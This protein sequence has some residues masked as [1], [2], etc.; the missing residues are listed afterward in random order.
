MQF[1]LSLIDFSI[2]PCPLVLQTLGGS[3]GRLLSLALLLLHSLDRSA[4]G[5]NQRRL[6]RFWAPRRQVRAR[7]REQGGVSRSG[8][9][10]SQPPTQSSDNLGAPHARRIRYSAS[11]QVFHSDY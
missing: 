8:A 6:P 5:G 10:S 9:I 4:A 3:I 11:A 1:R 2:E 7:F